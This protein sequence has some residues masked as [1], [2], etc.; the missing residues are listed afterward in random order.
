M[1]LPLSCK[2]ISCVTVQRLPLADQ[3]KREIQDR[4]DAYDAVV[5]DRLSNT[6]DDFGLPKDVPAWNRLS[7]NDED[8]DFIEDFN[9]VIKD[10]SLLEAD[11]LDKYQEQYTT[12]AFDGY[13]NMEIG[14]PRG[15]DDTL[16]HAKVKRRALDVD[17][18][19]IGVSNNNPIMDTRKYEV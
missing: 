5:K 3:Q 19:P 17:G 14:L 1:D 10:S 11:E 6:P 7:L 4:M 16:H 2:V 18:I 8:L 12:E 15:P 9:I 13:I